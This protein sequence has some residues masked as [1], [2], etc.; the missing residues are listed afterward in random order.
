MNF[1][2]KP[3]GMWATFAFDCPRCGQEATVTSGKPDRHDCEPHPITLAQLRE[4]I[5]RQI[6]G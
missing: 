6:H 4:V 3:R 5:E 2:T 1:R